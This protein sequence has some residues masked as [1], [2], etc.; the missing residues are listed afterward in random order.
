MSKLNADELDLLG[1]LVDRPELQ[2]FFFRKAKSL[3]WLPELHERGFF[4]PELNPRP[5][6]AGEEGFFKVPHWP[7]AE[8]LA[9]ASTELLDATCAGLA[10]TVAQIL[11]DV[12]VHAKEGGFSN[13]RTWWQFS[14]VL[15]NLP[16][17]VLTKS[18]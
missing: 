14:R 6:A 5:E 11:R 15:R 7:A 16:P 10:T 1:R 8:Y 13:Y 9:E 2:S 18:D 3:K 12:T 4:S 17:Q